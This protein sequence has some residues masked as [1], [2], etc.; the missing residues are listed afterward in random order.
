MKNS[1]DCKKLLSY[2]K[3][4]SIFAGILLV[5][6]F[7]FSCNNILMRNSGSL[8]ITVPGAR[9]ASA[10]TFTIELASASGFTQSETISGGSTIQFDDLAPDTYTINVKGMDDAGNKVLS[11]TAKA[12]VTAG[13]TESVTVNLESS[14]GNLTVSFEGAESDSVAKYTVILSGPNEFKETQEVT[15]RTVQFEGLIPGDYIVSVSGQDSD[16]AGVL[17]GTEEVTVPA[18]QTKSVTVELQKLLGSLTIDFSESATSSATEFKVELNIGDTLFKSKDVSGVTSVQFDDLVP[19]TYDIVVEGTN[20]AGAVIFYG[21]SSATVKAGETEPADVE[22]MKGASD[23]A[24]LEAAVAAGGTV[25][26]FESIDVES[27]LTVGTTVE[28]LPA[29][30]N[31]TLTNNSSENLFTVDTNGNLTIGGGEHT[32]TLDG[33][34]LQHHAIYMKNTGKATLSRNAIITN[35]GTASVKFYDYNTTAYFYLEGGSIMGNNGSGVEISSG[36]EFHMNSG[37]IEKNKA[38]NG[39]GVSLDGG[40]FYLNGGRITGNNAS[41]R[42]GG[43]NAGRGHL[44]MNGGYITENEATTDGGGVYFEKSI[45]MTGGYIERNKSLSNSGNGVFHNGDNGFEMRGSAVVAP[46]NDVYLNRYKTI[47]ITGE[48][49]VAT[50][51]P[52][53]TDGYAE[54]TQVLSAGDGVTLTEDIVSKFAVTPAP[55]GSQWTIDTS[56]NLQQDGAQ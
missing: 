9:A 54:G 30:Q 42:G 4:L 19:G 7:V 25:Y 43:V 10:S 2:G 17:S 1:L 36:S 28:I 39:G 52:N 45:V 40:K 35:C 48:S 29:Y 38:S 23:F 27:G 49:P 44:E 20:E 13:E 56:G 12:T 50:I 26:I 11:G 3:E 41:Q 8:V 47:T 51:T 14:L 18:G 15:D 53:K 31:V 24:S 33:N 6:L 16:G 34:T 21:T 55:D 22:L 5:L 37:I 46:D 32:I